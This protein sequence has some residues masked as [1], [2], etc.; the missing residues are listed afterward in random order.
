MLFSL[1]CGGILYNFKIKFRLV[2]ESHYV[3]VG[4]LFNLCCIC[5]DFN[6]MCSVLKNSK[7]KSSLIHLTTQSRNNP[8]LMSMIYDTF[9]VKPT[10]KE[11]FESIVITSC[12]DLQLRIR[13]INNQMY[14]TYPNS[15]T[16]HTPASSPIK[17]KI[18]TELFQ[19]EEWND[20]VVFITQY[21]H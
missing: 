10:K 21:F 11:K 19:E 5:K 12:K 16:L 20:F 4:S 2:L 14:L 1:K 15:S 17:K 18:K 7:L 9:S 13:K 6:A 3:S 8:I